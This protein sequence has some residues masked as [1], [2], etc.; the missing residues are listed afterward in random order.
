MTGPTQDQMVVEDRH[1]KASTVRPTGVA[2]KHTTS[3]IN[4]SDAMHD[5]ML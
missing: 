4:K 2:K 3:A 1:S 5:N